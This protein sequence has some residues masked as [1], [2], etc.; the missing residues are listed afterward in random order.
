LVARV[1]AAVEDGTSRAGTLG[2]ME[3]AAPRAGEAAPPD[4]LQL[5][6]PLPALVVWLRHVG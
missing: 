2:S 4:V 1:S 5:P 3:S 6:I